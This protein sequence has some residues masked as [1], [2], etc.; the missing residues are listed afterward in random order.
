MAIIFGL[1]C[2]GWG[3]LLSSLLIAVLSCMRRLAEIT[4]HQPTKMLARWGYWSLV[5]LAFITLHFNYV[6]GD[7]IG[8]H[9][10][11]SLGFYIGLAIPFVLGPD[12]R[13]TI[14]RYVS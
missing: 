3:L 12:R 7:D 10:L 5:G 6:E 8:R 9:T 1:T 14:V 4:G 2:A 11:A 13:R